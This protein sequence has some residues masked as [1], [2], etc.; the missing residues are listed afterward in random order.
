M[1][2]NDPKDD[3]FK[4]S[5]DLVQSSID[6]DIKSQGR[7][8]APDDAYDSPAAP[9][10]PRR[11]IFRYLALLF[12]LFIAG[13]AAAGLWARATLNRPVEHTA[14]DQIL[15][16]EPGTS[17]QAIIARLAEMGI[18][19]NPTLLRVYLRV[20]GQAAGLKAG[21]Y[22]FE[23][24]ISPLQALDKIRRCAVSFERVTIPEG[25]N[26]FDIAATLATTGLAS[27]E[28]FLDLMD[29]PALIARISP[30]ARNL[31]GYLFPDTYNYTEKTTPEELIRAMV[32]R[33]EE[34]WTPEWTAQASRL[35]KSVHEIVTLASII[36]EEA[37]QPD[38]RPRISS[39]FWNRLKIGMPLASDPTFIYAAILAKDYDDNPNQPRHRARVSPYNTYRVAGL[40]PGPIASPGR[41]SL[42]AAL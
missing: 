18:V 23:S 37:R 20:T 42:E 13:I 5:H 25:F 4:E 15:S 35:G 24:P 16:V 33:F 39:V 14:A 38:E 21:S 10:K 2:T 19:R 7:R 11:R 29:D 34:V 41:A 26:R 1:N 27:E 32:R 6:E 40:P 30:T 31:E 36:E 9:R 28:R 3:P 17:T 8:A 22:K 12:L